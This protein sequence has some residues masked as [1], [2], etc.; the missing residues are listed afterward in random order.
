MKECEKTKSDEHEKQLEQSIKIQL[1]HQ[2][3]K[4][5]NETSQDMKTFEGNTHQY[6]NIRLE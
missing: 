2:K 3:S 1:K 6:L 4:R 5:R